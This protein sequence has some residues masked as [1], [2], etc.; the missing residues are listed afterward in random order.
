MK[1]FLFNIVAFV[2]IAFTTLMICV[3][4]TSAIVDSKEFNNGSTESNTLVFHEN[5]QY[6]LMISGISH[7]RFFSRYQHHQIVEGLLDKKMINIGQ[8]SNICGV[9][10][11]YF[12]LRFFLDQGNTTRQLVYF[13]SPPML[14]SETLPIASNTF[15]YERFDFSFL[16][17]YLNSES[18]NKRQRIFSYIKSKL[19]PSWLFHNG[20]K[21]N[22]IYNKL[23]KIDQDVVKKGFIEAY[24]ENGPSNDRF[25]KSCKVLEE[26]IIFCQKHGIS[27]A[28]V[29][30]PALFGKWPGHQE[31]VKFAERM[32]QQYSIQYYDHAEA[33]LEPTLYKDHHHLNT[34]GI[35]YYTAHYL[36][37]IINEKDLITGN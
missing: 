6:D 35:K 17:A 7:A 25:L 9:N 10:E 34:E 20:S 24:G 29:I 13:L 5:E 11:Q 4:S 36:K 22:G 37:D 12:Y 18:E 3:M 2:L 31:V 14:Y 32:H 30:P 23:D 1:K 27:F 28:F 15:D 19:K 21:Q 16:W 33:V 26:E 8:G